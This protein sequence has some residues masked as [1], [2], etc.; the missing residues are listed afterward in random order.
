[1]RYLEDAQKFKASP[2]A[3]AVLAAFKTDLVELEQIC[4]EELRECGVSD[5]GAFLVTA[6]VMAHRAACFVVTVDFVFNNIMPSKENWYDLV[7]ITFDRATA[8]IA[9]NLVAGLDPERAR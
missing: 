7:G 1:M 2:R 8:E 3:H 9:K 5:A 6:E 4:V